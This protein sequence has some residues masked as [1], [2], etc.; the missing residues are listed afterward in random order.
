MQFHRQFDISSGNF[1]HNV[2]K[3]L[4]SEVGA[5]LHADVFD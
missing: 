2:D 5:A 3:I 1:A 4:S